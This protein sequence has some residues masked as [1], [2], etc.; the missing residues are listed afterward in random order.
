MDTRHPTII[1]FEDDRGTL[2]MFRQ[3]Y[4]AAGFSF[5]GYAFPTDDVAEVVARQNPDIISMDITM[6]YMEG[7]EAA[8]LLKD[9]AR[10]KNILI[11]F[12]TSHDNRY[13]RSEA[14]TLGAVDYIVKDTMTPQQVVDR[15]KLLIA[16]R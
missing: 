7:L 3:L 6:P 9:D 8:R 16:S 12:L 14:E 10:T 5:I 13:D 11:L 15:V 1:M 4:M 2:A